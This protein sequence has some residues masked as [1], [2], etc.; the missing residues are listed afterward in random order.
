M[1]FVTGEEVLT[2]LVPAVAVIREGQALFVMTGRKGR[3]GYHT[4]FC[5]DKKLHFIVEKLNES[6]GL[7]LSQECIFFFVGLKSDICKNK[8]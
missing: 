4:V 5:F 2:N 1:T 3:V 7:G 6:Y 8:R